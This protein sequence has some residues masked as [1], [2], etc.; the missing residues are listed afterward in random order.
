MS[1]AGSVDSEISSV[2][3]RLITHVSLSWLRMKLRVDCNLLQLSCNALLVASLRKIDRYPLRVLIMARLIATKL[4]YGCNLAGWHPDTSARLAWLREHGL[5]SLS[6]APATTPGS[7]CVSVRVIPALTLPFW[8][9]HPGI[10]GCVLPATPCWCRGPNPSGGCK[11]QICP[12][13]DKTVA[14]EDT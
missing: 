8:I 1:A 13:N 5:F 14:R 4:V 12:R 6:Q 9:L 10:L 3:Y 11:L 7:D 2:D